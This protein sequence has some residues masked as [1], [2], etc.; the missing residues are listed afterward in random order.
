MK[1]RHQM[2][3][4]VNLLFLALVSCAPKGDKLLLGPGQALGT[5]LAR[6]TVLADGTKKPVVLILP[7]W[8]AN[9]TAGESFEA[10]LKKH[11]VSV[12]YTFLADV[13]DPMGRA[14]ALTAEDFSDALSKDASAGAIVS[15]AGAPL[16][17]A[18]EMA[19]MN[20][21][22][23]P[24]LIV[25]SRSLGNVI[26]VPT[27]LDALADLL[28]AK[29][30]QL[31]IVDGNSEPNANPDGKTDATQQLFFEHYSIRRRRE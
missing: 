9:S 15:L 24:V 30:I 19:R 2:W 27:D 10:E 21:N 25:A 4:T 31:A 26:G 14:P 6:E 22:R 13:G 11:D 8:A 3:A 23:L 16:L 12:A 18:Q 1:P 28:N 29:V 5:V 7:K 20:T 17:S